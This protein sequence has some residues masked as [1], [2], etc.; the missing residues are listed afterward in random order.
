M[1]ATFIIL[2]EIVAVKIVQYDL[3]G[4]A[5]FAP[6]AVLIFSVTF[7]L[8]DIVNEKFGRRETHKMILIT[9]FCLLLMLLFIHL[10]TI[11]PGAPFWGSEKS[12][13]DIFTLVPRITIASLTA[14]LISENFDAWSYAKLR[15]KVGRRL[16]VRNAF[17]SIP[18]LGIDT[19]IFITLAFYGVPGIN[20]FLLMQGQFVLKWLT[21]IVDIPFMYIARWRITS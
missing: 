15:E 17:S 21:A 18:S 19:V 3:G 5:I 1:F 10:A 11:L 4:T 7:L 20:I 2:S 13:A 8:T 16:W 6:A 12:W 9:F 14:Y